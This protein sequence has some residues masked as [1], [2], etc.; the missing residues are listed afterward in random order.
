MTHILA[1]ATKILQPM[2]FANSNNTFARG[3]VYWISFFFF[4]EVSWTSESALTILLCHL[5]FFFCP[6]TAT[7]PSSIR[8]SF[9][10]AAAHSMMPSAA[11][12]PQ[13][14]WPV[15]WGAKA[16]SNKSVTICKSDFTAS[17]PKICTQ[18]PLSSHSPAT[19]RI[20]A[21]WEDIVRNVPCESIFG[22][23]AGEWAFPF[24]HAKCQSQ[25][26]NARWSGEDAT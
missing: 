16:S 22:E 11:A 4:S 1:E 25:F 12:S 10:R 20:K 17:Q 5:K 2:C 6:R 19:S 13:H 9:V 3:K 8:S 18:R 15:A 21:T 7:I 24:K 26:A 23:P 14:S